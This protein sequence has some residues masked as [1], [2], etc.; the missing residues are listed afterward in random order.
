MTGEWGKN[1]T[2]E[3]A[4]TEDEAAAEKGAGAPDEQTP[5]AQA[6]PDPA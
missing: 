5:Q 4:R 2:E 6:E 3:P 1:M